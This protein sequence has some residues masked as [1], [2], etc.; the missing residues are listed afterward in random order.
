MKA[1]TIAI[2]FITLSGTAIAKNRNL[3]S[4]LPLRAKCSNSNLNMSSYAADQNGAVRFEIKRGAKISKYFFRYHD[5][6]VFEKK[7]GVIVAVDKNL[8]EKDSFGNGV[9][10][11]F[12]PTGK[13]ID[14]TLKTAVLAAD[15]KLEELECEWAQN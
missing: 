7:D 15:G 2:I 14:S 12:L 5:S 4:D 10:V 9:M 8:S 1:L 6:Q 13:E 3:A 11:H